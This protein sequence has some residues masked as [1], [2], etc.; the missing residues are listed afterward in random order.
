MRTSR[1]LPPRTTHRLRI[2][3]LAGQIL[4]HLADD[5]FISDALSI[6][7]YVVL[8][9]PLSNAN[10]LDGRN[11]MEGG[12]EKDGRRPPALLVAHACVEQSMGDVSEYAGHDMHDTQGTSQYSSFTAG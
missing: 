11:G 6:K 12:G 2:A 1:L 5:V 7:G 9:R 8:R 4:S 3:P 10:L